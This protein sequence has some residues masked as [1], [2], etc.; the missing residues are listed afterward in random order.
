MNL[1]LIDSRIKDIE[2]IISSV[3]ESTAC[4]VFNYYHDTKETLLS[5]IKFINRRNRV[6][7]DFFFYEE[8]P[9][10]SVTDI[11]SCHTIDASGNTKQYMSLSDIALQVE[12]YNVH[13]KPALTGSE[14][15]SMSSSMPLPTPWMLSSVE[16]A[17]VIPVFFQRIRP[18]MDPVSGTTVLYPRPLPILVSQLDEIYETFKTIPYECDPD[19][20][21]QAYCTFSTV[22]IIQHSY[23]TN[24]I[25]T[26][27]FLKMLDS[28]PALLKN[29]QLHDPTLKTWEPFIMI[30]NE[31]ITRHQTQTLDLM[32]CALYS[33][34]DWKYVIDE[35]R[36]RTSLNIRAS[37]DDT[38]SSLTGGNWILETHDINLKEVYFTEAIDDWMHQLLDPGY[39]KCALLLIDNRVTDKNILVSLIPN[40]C[41][42]LFFDYYTDTLE[43]VL[44]KISNLNQDEIVYFNSIILIPDNSMAQYITPICSSSSSY[45]FL[46]SIAPSAVYNVE[47]DD[48][49]LE[50]WEDF[51]NMLLQ[52]KTVYHPISFE[53]LYPNL[54]FDV[55]WN[56]ILKNIKCKTQMQIRAVEWLDSVPGYFKQV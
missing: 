2:L 16:S 4:V 55:N 37:L 22:G 33:N 53:I 49:N 24:G 5:K 12:E 7:R 1:L 13:I 11:S 50:T 25:E 14:A 9:A 46:E 51:I 52:L 34:P 20:T 27:T 18:V 47:V 32:A 3:N 30:I 43:T 56:Y 31:L 35:L 19:N 6:I 28:N 41:C 10:L 42:Y 39:S 54:N 21:A 23:I 45:K 36:S 44:R 26:Y 29:V 38:G 17:R 15:D 48:P 8:P 40:N